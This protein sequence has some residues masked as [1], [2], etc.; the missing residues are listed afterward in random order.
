MNWKPSTRSSRMFF[1][2]TSTMRPASIELV[3]LQ[4]QWNII[5][6][7]ILL[8]FHDY[9]NLQKEILIPHGLCTLDSE[10]CCLNIL[11]LQCDISIKLSCLITDI[12]STFNYKHDVIIKKLMKEKHLQNCFNILTCNTQQWHAIPPIKPDFLS[13]YDFFSNVSTDF[14]KTFFLLLSALSNKNFSNF[15]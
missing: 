4:C 13:L 6:I 15:N 8:S 11:Q 2:Q 9:V 3:S 12:F 14:H 7:K 5:I 10:C 1:D